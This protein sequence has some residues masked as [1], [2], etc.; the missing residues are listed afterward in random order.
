MEEQ[1]RGDYDHN[2]LVSEL[3]M[4][5]VICRDSSP[6]NFGDLVKII[7]SLSEEKRKLIKNI[8]III[9]LVLTCGATTATPER[10]VSLLRRLKTW[11][12]STMTQKRLNSL[13]ILQENPTI[14]DQ[15][16]LIDVANDFVALHP[17]RLNIFGKFT[18][19]DLS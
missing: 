1:Y 16:S 19:K 2:S 15:M 4:L 5:P 9:R 3:D 11:L 8:I 17:S 14:V 10:S 7:Q 12:R 13:S 18:D 6:L